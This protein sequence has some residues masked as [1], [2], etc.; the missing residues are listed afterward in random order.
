MIRL[1]ARTIKAC[2][3][4][5]L[6]AA[7]IAFAQER[8]ATIPHAASLG[9]ENVL[10][11]APWRVAGKEGHLVCR[12]SERN[13]RGDDK[14]PLRELVVYRQEGTKV[15]KIFNFETPDSLLNVY[16]LGDYNARLF[17]TWVGGSAYHLRV[18]AFIDGQVRQVL[19]GG[20][21][22][23]PELLYDEHGD[24]SVLITDPVK[25]TGQWSAAGGTTTVFKWDG[26]KYEKIGTVPWTKRLQCTSRESCAS[27]E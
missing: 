24:E 3:V 10:A 12:V 20:T 21:K 11:L 1:I 8:P 6:F 2:V 7:P 9:D 23:A 22:I 5:L 16:A 25:E 19:D 18:W 14:L 27:L 17:T 26:R 4:L 15:T 13:M